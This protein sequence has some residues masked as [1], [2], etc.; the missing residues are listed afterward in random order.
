M[1]IRDAICVLENAGYEVI[2]KGR[3][4]VVKHQYPKANSKVKQDLAI[5]LFI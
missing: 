3:V 2:I 1:H 4:G 5:T